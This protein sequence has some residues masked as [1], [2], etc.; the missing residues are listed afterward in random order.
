MGMYFMFMSRKTQYCQD[1][2]YS[3]Q[4]I[5]SIQSQNS[6]KLLC[7]YWQTDYNV[8]FVRQKT[9]NRPNNIE[10]QEQNWEDSHYSTSRV[11]IKLKE[12]RHFRMTESDK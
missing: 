7:R 1:I 2:H 9:H 11:T 12:L 8:Y 6:S 4:S 3:R 5:Y 10:G